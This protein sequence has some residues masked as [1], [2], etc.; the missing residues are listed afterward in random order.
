MVNI[1]FKLKSWYLY[2]K[3]KEHIKCFEIVAYIM[4]DAILIKDYLCN[5]YKWE[6]VSLSSV[7]VNNE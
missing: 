7:M 5:K 2:Y 4:D 6:F 1:K 3:E